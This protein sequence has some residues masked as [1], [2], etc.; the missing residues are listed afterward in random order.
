MN[1]SDPI[2]EF[3]NVR[4]KD[5][6]RAA[7]L[8]I[9]DQ[10]VTCVYGES[11]AGKT[12]LLRLLNHLISPTDGTLSYR[13]TDVTE[14]DPVQLRREVVMLSQTPV[15]YDGTIR[16][17]LAMGLRFSERPVPDDSRL[18]HSLE[19]VQLAKALDTD[20]SKLSGGEKQRI[21]LARVMLMDPRV[22]LLDEPSAA[23]D[24][25]TETLVIEHVVR[26]AKDQER[27]VIMITH[28]RRIVEAY[29]EFLVEME[30]GDVR[31]AEEVS[32]TCQTEE[33]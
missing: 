15:M 31:R 22:L 20:A 27:P 2:F 17:N 1:A 26:Y 30:H 18:E 14:L 28:A 8:R 7:K 10:T 23:L 13:G 19:E 3:H 33:S 16:D 29:A 24:E 12:T 11:G 21:A 9:P 4:Y 25:D 5:I 32:P 6:F